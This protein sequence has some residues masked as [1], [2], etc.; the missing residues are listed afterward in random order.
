MIPQQTLKRV[1]QNF[2]AFFK[3]HQDYQQQP[4][5]YSG[6]PRPPRFKRRNQD[7][8]IYT[9][10][11]FQVKQDKVVLEKGLEINLPQSLV[12]Q[13]L[14][15]IEIIPKPYCFYAVF[16]YEDLTTTYQ[17]VVA[18]Q[19]TMAIDLGLNNLVTCVTNGI[20]PPFII[21]GKRLKSI[22]AYYHK[23]KAKLQAKLEVQRQQKWSANLQRLTDWRQAVITDYL[24]R[25]SH[26]IV[27]TCVA[28]QISQVVIGVFF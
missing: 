28:H 11:A 24:H 3:A 17:S 4:H 19:R 21:D 1:E 20:I 22:N 5:K 25:A 16:T 23:R 15:Q 9:Y 12:G 2:K 18:S 6:K 13:T 10:Q 26:Q 8:L 7:N 14:K 27:T